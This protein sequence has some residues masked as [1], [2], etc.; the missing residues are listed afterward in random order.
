MINLVELRNKARY[1][2]VVTNFETI[3]A[4]KTS[5]DYKYR[6]IEYKRY[7]INRNDKRY[8]QSKH[9]IDTYLSKKKLFNDEQ[10]VRPYLK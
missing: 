3:E 2:Y 10:I 6:L 5:P 9:E 4:L 1:S 8:F 7:I